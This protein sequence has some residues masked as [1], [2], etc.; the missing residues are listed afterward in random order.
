[1]ELYLVHSGQK[2]LIGESERE[3]LESYPVPYTFKLEKAAEIKSFFFPVQGQMGE[4]IQLL[5][6]VPKKDEP[7][8][9]MVPA[10]II[11]KLS[12]QDEVSVLYKRFRAEAAGLTLETNF[13]SQDVKKLIQ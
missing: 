3:N 1:M 9:V 12:A 5:S 6:L 7:V 10:E 11:V 4:L 8:D 13:N 2:I